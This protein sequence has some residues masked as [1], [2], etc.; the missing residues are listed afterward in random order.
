MADFKNVAPLA[1]FD[2]EA[3][4]SGDNNS[5]TSREAQEAAYDGSLNKV[6]DHDVVDGTVI[7]INKKKAAEAAAAAEAATEEVAPEAVAEEAVAEVATEE[8]AAEAATEEV[9]E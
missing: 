1:D 5:N 2:W 4:A 7:A 6:N 8:V 9:A 3:Y